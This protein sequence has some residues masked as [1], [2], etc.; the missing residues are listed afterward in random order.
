MLMVCLAARRSYLVPSR[1]LGC[2]VL[3]G[4]CN[5]TAALCI[6]QQRTNCSILSKRKVLGIHRSQ[7]LAA[8]KGSLS[9]LCQCA[10]DQLDERTMPDM[11]KRGAAVGSMLATAMEEEE[12]L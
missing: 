9:S 1:Y 8:I 11:Y 12:N 7:H 4:L 3:S 6:L 2:T 10:P 5:S